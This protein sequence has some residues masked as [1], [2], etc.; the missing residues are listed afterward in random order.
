[1]NLVEHLRKS[2]QYLE[3][4]FEVTNDVASDFATHAAP[5]LVDV[6]MAYL[7]GSNVVR[8]LGWPVAVGYS[9]G[10]GTEL[11]GLSAARLALRLREYNNTR[12]EGAHPAPTGLAT[13]MNVLY[14]A[15]GFALAA[16]GGF[17]NQGDYTRM[18]FPVL[19]IVGTITHALY[20]DHKQRL[21]DNEAK[22]AKAEHQE[23]LAQ[24]REDR[25]QRRQEVAATVAQP[26]AT[27]DRRAAILD[28]L[29]NDAYA[30]PSDIA[31]QIGVTRQAV[32]KRL[33]TLQRQGAIVAANGDGWKVLA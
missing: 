31:Q 15:G 4:F 8:Y 11:I 25:A 9:A 32:A 5:W 24:R 26:A 19:S 6:P 1:M 20:L 22:R 10:I 30:T 3:R 23:E 21:V 17:Q 16:L 27:V 14:F 13:G 2:P 29:R 7:A 18:I 28:A 33:E 12:P